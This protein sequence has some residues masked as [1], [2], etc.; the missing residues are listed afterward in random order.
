MF[1][2]LIVRITI[3]TQRKFAMTITYCVI[4]VYVGMATCVNG[5]VFMTR[6]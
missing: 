6:S 4:H 5:M 3:G 1:F 2:G